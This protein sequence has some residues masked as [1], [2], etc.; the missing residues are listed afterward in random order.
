MLVINLE[1]LSS[2]PNIRSEFYF[3]HIPTRFPFQLRGPVINL[4]R[5]DAT[6]GIN[7]RS[8]EAAGIFIEFRGWN[9]GIVAAV[10]QEF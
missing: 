10:T 9:N 7:F 1:F 3:L 6:S 5:L 4:H 2:L 8:G